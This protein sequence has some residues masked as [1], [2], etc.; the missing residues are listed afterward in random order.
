MR[1]LAKLGLLTLVVGLFLASCSSK[2]CTDIDC[3]N[4]DAKA[5]EDDG[6]CN[7][8]EEVVDTTDTTA[9][10]TTTNTNEYTV[11]TTYTFV[12]AAG[13]STVYYGGQSER[14]SMMAE[15][16]T[17][18]KTGN[19]AGTVLD[20]QLLKDMYSNENDAFTDTT[21]N[22][23]SK[24]VKSKTYSDVQLAFEDLMDSMAVASA[25]DA[26]GS[27]GVA[28]IVTSGD[29]A[30][31]Y[32]MDANGFEYTQ[33]IEKGLMGALMYFQITSIYL[34]DDKIGSS[35][36]NVTQ[37]D[38]AA[39][40]YY[41]SMEHHWDEAFGYFGVPVDFPT[42]TSGVQ[43]IG[44]YSNEVDAIMGTN[45]KLMDAFLTGR[46]G[47][48]NDDMVA[49][50]AAVVTIRKEMELVFG[51]VAI[52]Y[53][54]GGIANIGDDAIRN[55]QLSE[56]V[57]FIQGLQYN[58]DRTITDEKIIAVLALIG[59]NLYEVSPTMLNAAKDLLSTELGLDAVKDNL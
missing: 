27:N 45:K 14:L 46:A 40:K 29:G 50:D 9:T 59:D 8:E 32:L 51:A 42:V 33:L 34:A 16:T 1:R 38:T 23:S 56:A 49:K 12:D 54:N 21:L 58:V 53:L 47:I 39:G 41:T 55:H 5:K 19:T 48:S 36:D 17:Y 3:T 30:K 18:M 6:S 11:P 15:M 52:H 28:G 26:V 35:V 25:A 31:T 4:Y 13:N 43:Y 22:A 2:G 44:K 20:A 7:C 24:Q 10:D 57:A 37:S